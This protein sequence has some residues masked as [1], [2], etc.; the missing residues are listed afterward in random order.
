MLNFD[1]N[2]WATLVAI[3]AAFAIGSLWYSSLMFG[4]IWQREV[5]LSDEEMSSTNMV[6]IFGTTIIMAAIAAVLFAAHLGPD[7]ELGDSVVFGLIVGVGWIATSF[8]TGYLF[9][10]RSFTLWLI[11]S[12][13][14]VAL[15]LA[16]GLIIGVWP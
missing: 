11:N 1:I 7:P 16:F 8:A 6:A 2:W 12:G 3:V 5:K 15:F 4:K 13:Y 9:E 10:R 14:N